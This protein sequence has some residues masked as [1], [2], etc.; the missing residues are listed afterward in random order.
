MLSTWLNKRTS[1]LSVPNHDSSWG[2][3]WTTPGNFIAIY[4]LQ[5]FFYW[6]LTIGCQTTGVVAWTLCW[7]EVWIAGRDEISI[8]MKCIWAFIGNLI[9]R[10]SRCN[11]QHTKECCYVHGAQCTLSSDSKIVWNEKFWSEKMSNFARYSGPY[12]H[13]I[14]LGDRCSPR[15]SDWL[16]QIWRT[17]FNEYIQWLWLLIAWQCSMSIAC[18]SI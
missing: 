3:I 12:H 14:L 16:H 5:H 6:N 9:M 4:E 11:L 1:L 17:I 8:I 10:N 2:Y 18:F 7:I 15:E 13:L